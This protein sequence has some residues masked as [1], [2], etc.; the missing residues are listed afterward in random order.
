MLRLSGPDARPLLQRGV[1]IDLHP[2]SFARGSIAVTA[3]AHIDVV[4]RQIDNRPTFDIAIFRSFAGSFRHWLDSAAAAI[5][6]SAH[7]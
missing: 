5:M 7:P 4:I 3:I 6:S 2:A 1:S